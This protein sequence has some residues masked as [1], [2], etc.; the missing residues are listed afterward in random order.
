MPKSVGGA[1]QASGAS[2][3]SRGGAQYRK[4]ADHSSVDEALFAK[5]PAAAAGGGGEFPSLSGGGA[6]RPG[7]RGAFEK[8][9]LVISETQLASLRSSARIIT[10]EDKA[11]E[12]KAAE[13]KM[14][15]QRKAAK[16]RLD[17]LIGCCVA[18]LCVQRRLALLLGPWRRRGPSA[19]RS[20]GEPGRLWRP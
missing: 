10:A 8:E 12:K 4:V 5:K 14:W 9:P 18:L 1:S 13:D 11:A 2:R 19:E 17:L 6:A 7:V 3:G 20:L 15:E 16:V